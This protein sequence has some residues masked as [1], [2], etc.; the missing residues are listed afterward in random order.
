[1][2]ALIVLQQLSL[3]FNSVNK[4]VLDVYINKQIIIFILNT[5]LTSKSLSNLGDRIDKNKLRRS[6]NINQAIKPN[7]VF[8][9]KE[10]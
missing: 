7:R 9:Q 2:K 5:K 6:G 4:S 3:F 1:M 10:I 8:K